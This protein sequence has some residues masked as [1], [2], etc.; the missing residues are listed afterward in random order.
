MSA[1]PVLRCPLVSA[2]E[3]HER[4]T[5]RL[6]AWCPGK[7]ATLAAEPVIAAEDARVVEW[8]RFA[9]MPAGPIDV[10]VLTVHT[11]RETAHA[12]THHRH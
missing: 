1:L 6:P 2:H 10:S 4:T 9:G 8:R 7:A 11:R 5:G 3:P 12:R